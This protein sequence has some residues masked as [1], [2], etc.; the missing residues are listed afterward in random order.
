VY[1]STSSVKP[2]T[3]AVAE[4]KIAGKKLKKIIRDTK[5][6]VFNTG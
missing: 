3:G 1:V 4:I 5:E 6:K 2:V